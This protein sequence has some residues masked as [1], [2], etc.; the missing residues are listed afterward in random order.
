MEVPFPELLSPVS[1]TRVDGPSW[2]VTGFYYPSTRAVLTGAWF[3]LA[4]LTVET[5]LYVGFRA[6]ILISF[7]ISNSGPT[8][9]KPVVDF[10]HNKHWRSQDL[11]LGAWCFDYQCSSYARDNNIVK[12]LCDSFPSLVFLVR[13][14]I[15]LDL[16]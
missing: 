15:G 12:Y 8:L 9:N 11:W 16:I 3:Q 10:N 5:G 7:S 1:T 14:I 13:S 2:R 6:P 4:V